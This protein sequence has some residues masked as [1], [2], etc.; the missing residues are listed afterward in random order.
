[1]NP[2]L[3]DLDTSLSR[4][5]LS[6]FAPF[7][8]M[9]LAPTVLGSPARPSGRTL[10]HRYSFISDASGSVSG[11]AWDGG[12]IGP[13]LGPAATVNNGLTPPGSP[14]PT[15]CSGYYILSKTTQLNRP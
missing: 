12:L 10:E 9:A 5:A 2:N 4:R 7:P 3:N 13:T 1:M 8:L 15:T 6:H 14:T 11:A